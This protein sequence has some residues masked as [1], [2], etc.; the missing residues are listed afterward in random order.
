MPRHLPRR[1]LL[2]LLVLLCNCRGGCGRGGQSVAQLREDYAQQRSD[3]VAALEIAEAIK[4]SLL[5]ERLIVAGARVHALP[6]RPQRVALPTLGVGE[7]VLSFFQHDGWLHRYLARNNGVKS[8][9]PKAIREVDPLILSARDELEFGDLDGGRSDHLLARLHQLIMADVE[10]H[11][12][13]ITRLL[14]LPDGLL[15][16]IP[17]HAL[18]DGDASLAQRMAVVYAPCLALARK[19]PVGSSWRP[20]ASPSVVLAPIYAGDDKTH[21]QGARD[22]AQM[23]L[24]SVSRARLVQG[25]S[26]G[27]MILE[28]ALMKRHALVHFSGH[29]LADLSPE[30]TPELLFS[31]GQRP[32]TVRSV[33][34]QAAK[35]SLVVL[36]SCATAYVARFR[37]GQRLSAPVNFPEALLAAG[38]ESVVAA[39]W[40]IKDRWSARQMKT[41]Y[42]ALQRHDPVEAM[43]Q[44]YQ[45]GISQLSPPHPRFWA[46]YAIYGGW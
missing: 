6:G 32:A 7:A 39:S 24:H 31:D 20:L 27:A 29:G 34:H 5:R 18:S 40:S 45:Q 26:G 4:C 44:T 46:A 37:D 25:P 11:I 1:A 14:V 3:P 36:S 38:A 43:S 28:R 2:F 13:N 23:V 9:E 19:R 10:I 15:R 41:F 16:F 42:S 21:L 8:L 12:S 30:S 17:V 22:E 35:A 33:T